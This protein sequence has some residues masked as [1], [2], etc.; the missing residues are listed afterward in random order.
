M[1]D[2][3]MGDGRAGKRHLE[4]VLLGVLD[5]LLDRTRHF[6]ALPEPEADVSLSVA[7]DHQ[8]AQLK[9]A[10]ALDHFGH[11]VDINDFFLE[12]QL[13]WVN[14]LQ[15]MSFLKTQFRRPGRRRPMP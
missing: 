6:P 15:E 1:A 13:V 3:L 2:D 10:A 4:Q 11:A 7:D 8:G 14:P 12:L 9:P 5:S